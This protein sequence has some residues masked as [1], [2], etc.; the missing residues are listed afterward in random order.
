[1]FWT[2]VGMWGNTIQTEKTGLILSRQL[3]KKKS[4]SIC[5][6]KTMKNFN[7]TVGLMPW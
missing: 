1:M 5:H 3:L 6:R 2:T 4:E 7:C